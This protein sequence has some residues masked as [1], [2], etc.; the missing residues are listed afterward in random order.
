M[1]RTNTLD[2]VMGCC[3]Q[4]PPRLRGF[5]GPHL[6]SQADFDQS[7][8]NPKGTSAGGRV[9]TTLAPRRLSYSIIRRR[10][11]GVSVLAAVPSGIGQHAERHPH[12]RGCRLG[13]SRTTTA[14]DFGRAFWRGSRVAR[15]TYALGTGPN[16]E[17]RFRMQVD[18]LRLRITDRLGQHPVQVSLGR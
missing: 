15:S 1:I 16:V 12:Y 4:Q 8:P 3:S 13:A 10:G 17:R 11:C 7:A 5:S 2:G 6:G 18:R 9:G 14:L